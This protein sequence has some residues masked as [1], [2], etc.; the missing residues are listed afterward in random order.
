MAGNARAPA[1]APTWLDRPLVTIRATPVSRPGAAGWASSA[2][3]LAVISSDEVVPGE[4]VPG[5]GMP[6]EV[7]PDEVVPDEARRAMRPL[8]RYGSGGAKGTQ[9]PMETSK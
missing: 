7:V 1:E 5:E 8:C 3:L 4:V 2:M 6:G 9:G